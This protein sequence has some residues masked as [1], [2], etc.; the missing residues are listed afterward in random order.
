MGANKAN[1]GQI[2][3]HLRFIRFIRVYSRAINQ[4]LAFRNRSAFS[5]TDTE[6]NVIAALAIIGESSKPNIGNSTPAAM[7]TPTML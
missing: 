1:K 6:L 4:S 3:N 7:G 2:R 5:M